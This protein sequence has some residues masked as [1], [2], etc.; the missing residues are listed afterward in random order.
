MEKMEKDHKIIQ[1]LISDLS[2]LNFLLLDNKRMDEIINI[3]LN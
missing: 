1:I 2:E 3:N